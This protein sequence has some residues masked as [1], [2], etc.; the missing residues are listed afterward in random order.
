MTAVPRTTA[1]TPPL[2]KPERRVPGHVVRSTVLRTLAPAL[3]FVTVRAVGI[4]LLSVMAAL[5]NTRVTEELSSWD[6]QWFLDLAEHGYGGLAAEGHVDAFGRFS[7]ETPLG[8]FP[9][10]PAAVAVVRWTGTPTVVAGLLVSL[11]SGI[12]AAYA[13]VRLAEHV[14]GGCRRAGLV[15]VALFAAAPMGVVLSMTYAESLF[16]AL[17][18]WALVG[19]LEARWLL[20]GT[21]CCVAGLVRPTA[22][23]LLVAVVVAAVTA[24]A[25]CRTGRPLLAVAVAPLGLVGYL[26]FVAARTGT[27]DGWVGVQE[28]GWGWTLDGG[29]GSVRWIGDV[30]LR[31]GSVFEVGVAA[32]I[33]A[34]TVLLVIAVRHR[35][36]LPLAV[37]GAAVLLTAVGSSGLMF[38]KARLLVPAFVLLLPVA[39][40]LTRRRTGTVLGVL[41]VAA[42]VS[43]WFGA[44]ALTG[45]DNAI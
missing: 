24:I 13:L 20:A 19:V 34:S 22:I 10:Y 40:G 29:A 39:S 6:G 23:A 27:V 41:V 16:C 38:T 7:D 12:V 3:V 32:V 31:G 15:L 18:A 8:F 17:A 2:E 4:V 9:G 42:L 45:R 33:L 25:R 5:R 14:S 28:R 43:A 30:L 21:C 26:T 1:A 35:I 44:H 37:Y 11:L 36:P